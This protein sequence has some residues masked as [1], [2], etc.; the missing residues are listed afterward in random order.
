MTLAQLPA[1]IERLMNGYR[2]DYGTVCHAV[3][4]C[5]LAAAHAAN[6]TEGGGITGFQ[7]GAIMWEFIRHWRGLDGPTTLQEWG[8]ALYPQ[9]ADRFNSI[10]RDT[11]EWLQAEARKRLEEPGAHPNVQKHW[12]A[13]AAG[14]GPFGLKVSDPA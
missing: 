3:A 8:D 6:R 13:L 9:N 4:A 2:H 12:E 11:L 14:G 1:F 10:N 7:A 5:A